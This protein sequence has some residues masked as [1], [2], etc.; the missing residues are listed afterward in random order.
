M[1]FRIYIN[2][3]ICVNV[4]RVAVELGEPITTGKNVN[5]NKKKKKKNDNGEGTYNVYKYI[6]IYIYIYINGN[7]RIN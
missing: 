2:E 3:F 7:I 1:I 4:Y 6:Y 5:E